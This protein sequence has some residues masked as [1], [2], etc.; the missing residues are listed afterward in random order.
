MYRKFA[1]ILVS[2]SLFLSLGCETSG[3]NTETLQREPSWA[4][5]GYLTPGPTSE[6]SL[7][8][9]YRTKDACENAIDSWM[10]QQVV[11]NPVFAECLPIDR[12]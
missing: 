1:F 11:G 4:G 3:N 7:I 9:F 8:G 6:P 5:N 12:N 10:S 2:S